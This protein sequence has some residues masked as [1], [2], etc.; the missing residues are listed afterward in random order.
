MIRLRPGASSTAQEHGGQSVTVDPASYLYVEEALET[1]GARLKIMNRDE[2]AIFNVLGNDYDVVIMGE[3]DNYQTLAKI[4]AVLKLR[5]Y[6]AKTHPIV[7]SEEYRR[8]AE[9]TASLFRRVSERAI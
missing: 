4:D 6:I 8:L 3:V 1:L 2:P 5:G 7:Q 9:E